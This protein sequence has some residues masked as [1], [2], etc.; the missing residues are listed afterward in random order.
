MPCEVT[1]Q[2]APH[3]LFQAKGAASPAPLRRLSGVMTGLSAPCCSSSPSS[4]A[5]EEAPLSEEDEGS[6]ESLA[7]FE[8]HKVLAAA[9]QELDRCANAA[10]S[11]ADDKNLDGL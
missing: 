11:G 10:D 9:S 5:E 6:S 8:D 4:P 7:A 3:L 2:L 1:G